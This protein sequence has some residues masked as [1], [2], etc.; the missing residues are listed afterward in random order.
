VGDRSAIRGLTGRAL[1]VDMDPLMIVGRVGE[2]VYRRLIN[3]EPTA[4]AKWLAN[5]VEQIA[6]L[7]TRH[8]IMGTRS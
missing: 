2:L 3:V 1:G 4:D 7:G 5:V 8:R 6:G